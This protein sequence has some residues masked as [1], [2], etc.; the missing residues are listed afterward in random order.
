MELERK[1]FGDPN[2]WSLDRLIRKFSVHRTSEGQYQDAL[3]SGQET[4]RTS[5][6]DAN[7]ARNLDDRR[8]ATQAMEPTAGKAARDKIQHCVLSRRRAQYL[9]RVAI[10]TERMSTKSKTFAMTRQSSESRDKAERNL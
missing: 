2:E 10:R 7:L 3:D 8:M 9:S 1:D 6:S 4:S 5:S